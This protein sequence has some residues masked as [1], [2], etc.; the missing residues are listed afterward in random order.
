MAQ[1]NSFDGIQTYDLHDTGAKIYDLYLIRI[2]NNV[3]CFDQFRLHTQMLLYYCL[4]QSVPHGFTFP[5]IYSYCKFP[6]HTATK[7]H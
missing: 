7:K 1:K 4:S 6:L 3:Y 5:F 2:M